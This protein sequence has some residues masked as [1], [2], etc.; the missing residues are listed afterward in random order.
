M[1]SFIDIYLSEI[2]NK[3]TLN[4]LIFKNTIVYVSKKDNND[5]DIFVPAFKENNKILYF[6]HLNYYSEHDDIS[7]S[8]N[9]ILFYYGFDS[10]NIYKPNSIPVNYLIEKINCDVYLEIWDYE[11]KYRYGLSSI[12]LSNVKNSSIFNKEVLFT[13]SDEEFMLNK[14][15]LKN[16]KEFITKFNNY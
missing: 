11:S 5:L 1:K 9:Y 10:D 2:S 6:K 12:K 8:K 13:R 4:E 7:N 14:K 16:S 3:N 15:Y